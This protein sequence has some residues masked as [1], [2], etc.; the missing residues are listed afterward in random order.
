MNI[1]II[2]RNG[3]IYNWELPRFSDYMYT[4]KL[5]VVLDNEQWVGIYNINEVEA[6]EIKKDRI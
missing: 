4:D 2:M 6:I 5:F 3:H 1:T